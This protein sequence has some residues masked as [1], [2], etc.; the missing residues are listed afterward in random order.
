L[1]NAGA[2]TSHD[3]TQEQGGIIVSGQLAAVETA[4]TFNASGTFLSFG[5]F[6]E[7]QPAISGG[8]IAKEISDDFVCCGQVI[9][10][11]KGN[12]RETS[13]AFTS[14]GEIYLR[15]ALGGNE[16]SD[17]YQIDGRFVSERSDQP[18]INGKA[19]TIIDRARRIDDEEQLLAA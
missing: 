10:A 19:E 11:G 1:R 17:I 5:G 14:V 2:L 7:E 3:P 4:D 12:A 13:D 16:N 18:A 6:R 9:L 15:G 8:L